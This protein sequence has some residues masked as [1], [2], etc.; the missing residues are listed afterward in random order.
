MPSQRAPGNV[1]A[2]G[3][4]TLRSSGARVISPQPVDLVP[5]QRLVH[6]TRCELRGRA[7][8]FL[9]VS[10]L[11]FREPSCSDFG[12]SWRYRTFV[13]HL[14]HCSLQH[15]SQR[16]AHIETGWAGHDRC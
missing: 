10:R 16:I 4:S 5:S 6:R 13:G 11:T 2:R 15:M 9:W 12:D 3:V 1:R 7:I 8:P 14:R